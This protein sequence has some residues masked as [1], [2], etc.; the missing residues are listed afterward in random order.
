MLDAADPSVLGVLRRDA[1]RIAGL[2]E[3]TGGRPPMHWTGIP[4]PPRPAAASTGYCLVISVGGT[5][6]EHALMRLEG[7]VVRIVA[8]DG[9]EVSGAEAAGAKGALSFPTPTQADTLDGL[10]MIER[11]AERIAA[12]LRPHRKLLEGCSSTLLSW[13]F[14]HKVVRTGPHVLG[15]VTALTTVMTKEQAAFTRDL[16]GKDLGALFRA[17]FERRLGWSSP[18]TAAND[19]IMALHYF[20]TAE[21]MASSARF[22]LFI[23][24]TGTNFAAAEPYAVRPEGVLSRAGEAYQPE[25]ITSSRPLHPGERRDLYFVNYETGSIDLGVTRTPF[26][27]DC[28]YPIEG[29]ALSGGRAFE[30]SFREVVRGRVSPRVHDALAER[31]RPPPGGAPGAPPRG[32]EVSRIAAEGPSAVDA[33]FPGHG[34]AAADRERVCLVCRAIVARSALHVALLLSAVTLR[35]GYGLGDGDGDEA[36]GR[37]D[38]LAMEGSVWRT[39]GYPDLVREGWQ[40][41]VGPRPLR[42]RFEHEPGFDASLPGPLYLAAVHG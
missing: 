3:G 4:S 16:A 39:P 19:G 42:V 37:P 8:P 6:T 20:L 28:E 13:G 21:N 27:V 17:A 12:Y 23:N 25:R 33:V 40:A 36:P 29:N 9:G 1:E 10:E 5:K 11:I 35:S 14:A 2:M 30:Q 26:D 41:I 31:F 38:L 18:V 22:G 32:P 15:G 7:G 34:I 24:G